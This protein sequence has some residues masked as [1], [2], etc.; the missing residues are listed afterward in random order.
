MSAKGL[1]LLEPLLPKRRIAIV[2]VGTPKSART[3]EISY[4]DYIGS[5]EIYRRFNRLALPG[6]WPASCTAAG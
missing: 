4:R 3:A 2:A 5:E 6:K 1:A